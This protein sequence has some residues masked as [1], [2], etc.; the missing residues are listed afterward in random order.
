MQQD[1]VILRMTGVT[2]DFPGVRALDHVDLE[3]RRGEVHA[4]VGENGAGKST[5]IKILAGVYAMDSGEVFLDGK[6]V[7]IREPCETQELGL[8]FVHQDLSLIPGFT[9]AQNMFL[10]REKTGRLGL[11]DWTAMNREAQELLQRFGIDLDPREKVKDLSIAQQ[12]LVALAKAL[13]LVPRLIVLD[14]PTAPLSSDEVERLCH[15]IQA[16]QEHGVTAIYIS[17]RLEEIRQLCDRV[18]VLRDGQLVGTLSAEADLSEIIGMMIGAQLQDKFYKEPVPIAGPVLQV[19]GLTRHGHVKDVSFSLHRGEVLG[20]G[21]L[22][23]A[24][25]SELLRLIFGADPKDS[26]EILLDGKPLDI[27]SPREAIDNGIALVPEDRRGQGVVVEMTVRENIT[28]SAI[29]QFCLAGF[30]VLLLVIFVV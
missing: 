7:E 3:I 22:L 28:M 1:D 30:V 14:E 13:A 24:G 2:K 17:H 29:G 9:I 18:T 23:G 11:I 26:G 19:K 25:R 4:L 21:G 8:A 15:V 16:L 5:L 6:K 27:R 10:T 20:I 12:Q